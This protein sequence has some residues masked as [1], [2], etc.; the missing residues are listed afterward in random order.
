MRCQRRRYAN[1]SERAI[2]GYWNVKA[3]VES[4]GWKDEA[5]ETGIV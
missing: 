5:D 2:N 3:R 1:G 4:G